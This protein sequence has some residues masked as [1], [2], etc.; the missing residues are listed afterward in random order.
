MKAFRRFTRKGL[1]RASVEIIWR[2]RSLHTQTDRDGFFRVLFQTATR[3]GG[4]INSNRLFKPADTKK[5]RVAVD[6]PPWN[7]T[8]TWASAGAGI[9]PV[10]LILHSARGRA[11]TRR[12]YTAKPIQG[13]AVAPVSQQ[14][15][16]VISDV[17]DTLIATYVTSKRKLLKTFLFKRFDQIHVFPGALEFVKQ[18]L[19]SPGGDGGGTLHYVT[20][21]PALIYDR[22]F[23]LFRL[24]QFP[25]GS[26]SMK[27]LRGKE[28]AGLADHLGYKTRL[29]VELLQRYP[30]RKFLLLGDSGEKDPE[31]YAGV[32]KRFPHRIAAIFIHH[33][34]KT[35]ISS[36]RFH[37]MVVFHRYEEAIQHARKMGIIR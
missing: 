32:R 27:Y 31:I 14:G 29:I 34:R 26:L 35:P 30:K 16:S 13:F 37:G 8:Q 7:N 6:W 17:D 15:L 19:A 24:R 25:L 11:P 10:Q 18:V 3:P 20:G 28:A 23:H 22:L 21:S 1:K 12:L 9:W 2:G 33:V 4:D 5:R 36:P